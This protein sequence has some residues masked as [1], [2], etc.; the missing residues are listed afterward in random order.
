[1]CAVSFCGA[2]RVAQLPLLCERAL[3]PNTSKHYK[4]KPQARLSAG[5]VG[6]QCGADGLGSRDPQCLRRPDGLLAAPQ[7]ERLRL[8]ARRHLQPHQPRDVVGG[9]DQLDSQRLRQVLSK[10]QMT[11]RE[12]THGVIL[13]HST[14]VF[15]LGVF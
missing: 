2:S 10:L 8:R 9:L 11:A 4:P 12:S 14:V 3:K 15:D 1:M 5:A 7:L 13:L 6:L